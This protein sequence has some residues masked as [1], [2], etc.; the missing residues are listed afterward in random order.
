[1][2]LQ[3]LSLQPRQCERYARARRS[4]EAAFSMPP[5]QVQAG[6]LAALVSRTRKFRVKDKVGVR[7][8]LGVRFY[9]VLV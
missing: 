8:S 9:I 1:M 5:R 7:Q 3:L 6:A 4:K 2:L